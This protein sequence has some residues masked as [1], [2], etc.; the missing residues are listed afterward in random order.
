MALAGALGIV[1]I[2]LLSLSLSHQ[3]KGV[4]FVLSGLETDVESGYQHLIPV[5]KSVCS[6]VYY[7]NN[8]DICVAFVL[9]V[10]SFHKRM[11]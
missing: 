11:R 5:R 3:T 2:L 6:C 7:N 8:H 9:F 4:F 10:V 1:L